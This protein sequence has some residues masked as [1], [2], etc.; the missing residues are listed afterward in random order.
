M[1]SLF[2]ISQFVLFS[3]T[4]SS[5]NHEIKI[6]AIDLIQLDPNLYYEYS[7]KKMGLE[8]GSSV[9]NSELGLIDG[10]LLSENFTRRS[11]SRIG[12]L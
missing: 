8:I 10:N 11:I 1:K 2:I 7:F 12:A 5:Q 6:S 9:R 4:S 3:L